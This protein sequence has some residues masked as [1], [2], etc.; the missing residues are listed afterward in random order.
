MNILFV[1][2]LCP[3]TNEEW[4]LPLTLLNFIL[5]FKTL[6]HN[7]TLLRANVIP[8]V[9]IRK[10]KILPEGEYDFKGIKCINKNFLT[11]FFSKA[12]FNFLNNQQ[13]DVILSHMPSGILAANQISKVL[14]IPYFASVHSSDIE[15]LQNPAYSFLWYSIKK[16]YHEAK[17]VLPRSYWLKDKIE[18]IIPGLKNK[19]Y[20]VPS[21]IEEKFYIEREDINQKAQKMLSSP[22]KILAAGSL[23]KRKN[24]KNLIKA[25]SNFDDI[26]Q[27]Q[28][29][30]YNTDVNIE[31]IDEGQ[32]IV[33]TYYTIDEAEENSYDLNLNIPY[34]N[35]DNETIASYNEEIKETYERKAESTLESE[36]QNII[37]TVQYEATIENDILSLIIRANLKEGSSAQRDIIQTF[38]YDL[39]NNKEISLEEAIEQKQ[40]DINDVQNKIDEEIALAEQQV[41][42]L[43]TLGYTIFDRNADDEM[44]KI[45]NTQEFFIKD[46]NIYIIYAYGN[47]NLTDA[48]DLIIV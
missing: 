29:E 36:N 33:Y 45:E 12:Q 37:Y 30:E 32:E 15:V 48:M 39:R 18:K 26:F 19:T 23:I 14:K 41:E 16:A 2:D 8:N 35:I 28:L 3:I 7:V 13:F 40:L 42:D 11:P 34:I 1:T 44:Y 4:G 9:F 27:N 6:G 17:L 21:G 38:N 31:K 10:R 22:L 46:G 47:E 20:I 24:F 43:R 25:I 5:D